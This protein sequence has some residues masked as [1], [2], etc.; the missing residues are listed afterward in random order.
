MNQC[1]QV[2]KIAGFLDMLFSWK[3]Y[4]P[5]SRL[6]YSIYLI[7]M[8]IVLAHFTS[9]ETPRYLSDYNL[10]STMI[11]AFGSLFRPGMQVMTRQTSLAKH[12]AAVTQA[13]TV[14]VSPCHICGGQS[15]TVTGVLRLTPI[16]V[17]TPMIRT[18]ISNTNRRRYIHSAIH[19][20]VK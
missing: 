13:V 17:R 9:I 16:S 19:S 20:V 12:T 5:L 11:V 1:S 18:P 14:T 10:V 4:V 8:T 6:T 7:H 3:F 15:S 2:D